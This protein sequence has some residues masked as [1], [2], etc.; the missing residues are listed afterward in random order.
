MLIEST[1][2]DGSKNNV[3]TYI[4]DWPA[5]NCDRDNDYFHGGF[6]LLMAGGVG[7]LIF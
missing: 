6:E 1:K 7:F 4:L 3:S 5:L 2:Q